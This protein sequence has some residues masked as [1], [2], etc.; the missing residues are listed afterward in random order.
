MKKLLT[1]TLLFPGILTHELAHYL[2][3]KILNVEVTKF[4]V[5]I[6]KQSGFVEHVVPKSIIKSLIISTGPLTISIILSFIILNTELPNTLLRLVSYYLAFTILY[7]SLPSKEDT[8]FHKHHI[9]SS[10]LRHQLDAAFDL[11]GDMRNYLY[12]PPKIITATFVG[13]HFGIY[14]S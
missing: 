8:N 6:T 3:C 11:V 10:L 7:N 4:K 9:S 1:N 14:L 12:S 5:S 2:M 13:N